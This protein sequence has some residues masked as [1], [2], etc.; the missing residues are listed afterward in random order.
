M[1]LHHLGTL[2]PPGFVTLLDQPFKRL[3]PIGQPSQ[4]L[5]N[6]GVALLSLLRQMRMGLGIEISQAVIH[7]PSTEL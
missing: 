1:N 5:R 6:I 7:D 3:S 4:H 2:R